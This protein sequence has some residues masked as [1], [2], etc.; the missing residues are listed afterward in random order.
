MENKRI[1]H[2]NE[3]SKVINPFVKIYINYF[4][5]NKWKISHD[6]VNSCI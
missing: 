3:K 1:V 2:R 5:M 6:K 4:D